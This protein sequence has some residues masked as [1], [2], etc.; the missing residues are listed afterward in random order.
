M[1]LLYKYMRMAALSLLHLVAALG[2]TSA[3][4]VV[5]SATR[6]GVARPG[7]AKSSYSGRADAVA[8]SLANILIVLS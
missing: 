7:V 6:C 4:T 1:G 2:C 8:A 3:P 5:I